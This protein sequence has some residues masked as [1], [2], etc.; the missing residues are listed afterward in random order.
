MKSA[1]SQRNFVAVDVL[2]RGWSGP[3]RINPMRLLVMRTGCAVHPRATARRG[4]GTMWTIM[5]S[6]VERLRR[7]DGGARVVPFWVAPAFLVIAVGLLPWIAWLFWSLP[8]EATAAHWRLAWGGFD[9]GLAL[10]LA[11]TAWLALRRSPLA[12]TAAA[13][14][15]T[16]LVC[17]AWFDVL[18]SR[19]TTDV[20][21]SAVLAVV[22]ELPLAV[23][24]FWIARSVE[25]V[26]EDAR[27]YLTAQ[28][29]RTEHRRLVPPD[30]PPTATSSSSP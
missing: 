22:A 2:G 21:V 28:G 29:F 17:D 4:T 11:S 9:I 19:G 10:A 5:S 20:V 6:L 24:C 30:E 8:D 1:A 23:L 25:R 7:L 14:T 27:P 12:Q 15:G 13:V 3:L 18:T 16:M 26:L